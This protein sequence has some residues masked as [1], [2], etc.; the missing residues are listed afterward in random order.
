VAVLVGL[1]GSLP[2]AGVEPRESVCGHGAVCGHRS[3]DETSA[4][5]RCGSPRGNL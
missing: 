4:A 5:E 2:S 1:S 3:S